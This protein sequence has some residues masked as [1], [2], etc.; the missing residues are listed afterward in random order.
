MSIADAPITDN[1]IGITTFPLLRLPAELRLKI[2]EY[3]LCSPL[4]LVDAHMV[5]HRTQEHEDDF[6]PV[7]R[8]KLSSMNS[9]RR[10]F[11][12]PK[13]LRHCRSYNYSEVQLR[14]THP[15]I[16]VNIDEP[17]L[18]IGKV[19]LLD[20]HQLC[21]NG[22]AS[23]IKSLRAIHP[24]LATCKTIY[25]EGISLY[26]RLNTFNV[27]LEILLDHLKSPLEENNFS[28]WLQ[29]ELT[30]LTVSTT[31]ISY[32]P[33][34]LLPIR[35]CSALHTLRLV[36]ECPISPGYVPRLEYPY[37]RSEVEE[38]VACLPRLRVFELWRHYAR[39]LHAEESPTQVLEA[40]ED[41]SQLFY[42]PEIQIQ[43]VRAEAEIREI[44][45]ARDE[46]SGHRS[47]EVSHVLSM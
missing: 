39:R 19:T 17:W 27:P 45:R 28:C 20:M 23:S 4:R 41:G 12:T 35:Q 32:R 1:T 38:L 31:R 33:I 13:R 24:L 11:V 36:L 29:T 40:L 34:S 25:R 16:P 6:F 30:S 2:Y 21:Q 9:T 15:E 18:E 37:S 14:R 42:W 22:Q 26:H 47:V 44:L 5:H 3:A 7:K 10:T 43:D 8:R 46:G